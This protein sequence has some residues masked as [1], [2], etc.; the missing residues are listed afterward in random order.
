MINII[1]I[2]NEIICLV[3]VNTLK[4]IL[5]LS[6]IIIKSTHKCKQTNIS[7]IKVIKNSKIV[8]IGL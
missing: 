1:N 4:S 3:G 5:L 2:L 8:S 7:F 6:V